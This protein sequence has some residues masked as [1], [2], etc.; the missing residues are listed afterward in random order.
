MN[1]LEKKNN[2]LEKLSYIETINEFLKS[3]SEEF[4]NLI[5]RENSEIKTIDFYLNEN[6]AKLNFIGEEKSPLKIILKNI[7][8]YIKR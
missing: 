1:H 3:F 4:N 8:M 7:S 2:N 6:R 5:S